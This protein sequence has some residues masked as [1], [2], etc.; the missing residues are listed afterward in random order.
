MMVENL[1]SSKSIC[2]AAR[3]FAK[4]IF[5]NNNATDTA[6]RIEADRLA[7]LFGG[8]SPKRGEDRQDRSDPERQEF[9]NI[10]NDDA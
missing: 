5:Q 10:S 6:T 9:R 8:G 3:L 7:N 4:T 1:I 2:D